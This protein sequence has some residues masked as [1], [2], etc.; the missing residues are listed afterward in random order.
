MTELSPPYRSD[1]DD[2]QRHNKNY[3]A[4]ATQSHSVK[5]GKKDPTTEFRQIEQKKENPLVVS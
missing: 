1:T 3:G 4:C 2:Q 5:E